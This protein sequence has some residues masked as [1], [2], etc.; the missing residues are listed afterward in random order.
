MA[1]LRNNTDEKGASERAPTSP[2]GKQ[3]KFAAARMEVEHSLTAINSL[4]THWGAA[5]PVRLW[6]D[7]YYDLFTA[8]RWSGTYARLFGSFALFREWQSLR[9]GLGKMRR[10]LSPRRWK[11][12]IELPVQVPADAVVFPASGFCDGVVIV[13]WGEQKVLKVVFN[14]A[15]VSHMANERR[16][17]GIAQQAGITAHVPR[18]IETGTLASGAEWMVSE[19]VPNTEPFSPIYK[20]QWR[21]WLIEEGLPTLA[22]FHEAAGVVRHSAAEMLQDV[23]EI[24]HS[25]NNV[26]VY[27]E[28]LTQ[29]MA[30]REAAAG[31]GIVLE[32][33][34]HGDL[35]PRHVH[36]RRS[37]WW[38]LDWGAMKQQPLYFDLL[39]HH[40]RSPPERSGECKRFWAW[41][42]YEI[43]TASL[44]SDMKTDVELYLQWTNE[45]LGLARSPEQLRFG[46]NARML[47]EITAVAYPEG[48]AATLTMEERVERI[49]SNPVERMWLYALCSG[50]AAFSPYVMLRKSKDTSKPK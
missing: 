1:S 11:G 6:W 43:P 13:S 7:A 10:F 39:R 37:R 15:S 28:R 5:A 27:L 41:L 34:A 23:R 46:I 8:K 29:A 31:D 25:A 16:A 4:S 19:A 45:W 21:R 17:W 47:Q 12:P 18:I 14:E 26:P 48:G 32:S 9:Y 2:E 40:V 22:R 44:P 42:R 24:L 50:N 35:L 3:T 49:V 36:R 20:R 33:L 30:E 38:L